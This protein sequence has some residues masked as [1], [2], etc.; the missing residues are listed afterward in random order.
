V[1]FGF[2]RIAKEI[3]AIC[4]ALGLSVIPAASKNNNVVVPPGNWGGLESLPP[5]T[6]ISVRMTFGDKIEGKFMSMDSDGIRLT[7]DEK[8]RIYPRSDVAEVRQL[9][10]PDSKLNG[11]LIGMGA[12][13]AAG[14]IAAGTLGQL[15]EN[16]SNESYGA[17]LLVLGIGIGTAA[18]LA[19]DTAVKGDRLIY[20]K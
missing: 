7:M 13:A 8:E 17:L 6:E 16:E 10:V 11:T 3:L 4:L 5:G 2:K 14:G 19:I 12:G 9:H 20:R 1:V 18:G 15:L